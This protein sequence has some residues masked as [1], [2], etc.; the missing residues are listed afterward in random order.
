M[1]WSRAIHPYK[2]GGV[3]SSPQRFRQAGSCSTYWGCT[4]LRMPRNVCGSTRSRKRARSSWSAVEQHQ[5]NM[6]CPMALT[7]A[8]HFHRPDG[9][10]ASYRYMC[11]QVVDKFRGAVERIR[12]GH[13]TD[14]PPHRPLLPANPSIFS[15][16]CLPTT[17]RFQCNKI[18]IVP[19]LLR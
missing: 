1:A 7:R 14:P 17:L 16:P 9:L 4:G 15:R 12:V 3:V 10:A 5:C 13:S 18:A 8:H 19:L 11:I 2:I 6:D